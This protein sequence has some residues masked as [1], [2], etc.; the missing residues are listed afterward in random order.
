VWGRRLPY[1]RTTNSLANSWK[2]SHKILIIV[3]SAQVHIVDGGHF[4]LDTV[5]DEIAA[6][7]REFMDMPKELIP[8]EEIMATATTPAR[9][10]FPPFTRDSAVQKVR[11]AEDAWNTRDPAKVALAYAIDSR[12]RNRSVP[13]WT[14]RNHCF[15]LSQMGQGAGVQAYQGTV[16]V[17]WEP[18]RGTL[19]LRVARRLRSL[20]SLLWQ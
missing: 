3:P 10:P 16:G 9:P 8:G 2:R 17:H 14:N 5:P 19:R 18:D 12:W 6:R 4:S 20:V 11:L 1:E 7:V 13:L 15:P